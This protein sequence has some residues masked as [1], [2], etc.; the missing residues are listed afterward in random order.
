MNPILPNVHVFEHGDRWYAYDSAPNQIYGIDESVAAVLQ[1]RA[2]ELDDAALAIANDEIA[3]A[4]A[5][6]VFLEYSPFLESS[7]A[8]CRDDVDR[9]PIRQ[10]T[11]T[12]TERCDY[13]C[14]YCPYTHGGLDWQRPHDSRTIP[15]PTLRSALGYFLDRCDQVS[16]PAIAFYGGEPLLE[17]DLLVKAS[18]FIRS[19]PGGDAVRITV[20][21]NGAGL[22]SSRTIEA[23]IGNRWGFQVSLDGP[24]AIHDRHRRTIDGS[25]T[26]ARIMA[27]L[28]KLYDADPTIHERIRYQATVVDARDLGTV[29]DWF[30]NFPIHVQYGIEAAPFVGVNL[31]DLSGTDLS[32]FGLDDDDYRNRMQHVASLAGRYIEALAGG[33]PERVDPVSRSLFEQELIRHHHRDRRHAPESLSPAGCCKAG[34]RRL[35]VTVDGTYQPCERVGRFMEIGDV[36]QGVNPVAATATVDRFVEAVGDRCSSCWAVRNCTLCAA[37]LG[38]TWKGDGKGSTIDEGWCRGTR[39]ALEKRLRLWLEIYERNPDALEFLK[40]SVL[41]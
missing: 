25:P 32:A 4:R 3:S 12:L 22:T 31:A 1:G 17:V 16:D 15:W 26:H 33:H 27:G 18:S 36:E 11:V 21:T 13:R 7:C 8:S 23:A 14:A 9:G 35:H 39:D 41:S 29:A 40:T 37:T 28:D 38:E 24:A 19:H 34:L 20:D 30:Q 5:E 10:L 6:G 2:A